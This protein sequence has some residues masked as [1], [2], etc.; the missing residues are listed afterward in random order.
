[1]PR[2]SRYRTKTGRIT[3]LR[4]KC[5]SPMKAGVSAETG[6]GR[7]GGR[8]QHRGALRPLVPDS[9]RRLIEPGMR[10]SRTRLTDVLRRWHSASPATAGWAAARRRCR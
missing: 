10:F 9:S 6:G 7:V 1:M 5:S 8:R 4:A 2:C 3:R